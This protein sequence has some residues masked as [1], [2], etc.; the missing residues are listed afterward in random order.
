MCDH[1]DQL[2]RGDFLEQIHDLDRGLGIQRTRRLVGQEDIRIVYQR[3]RDRDA[4]HLSAGHLIWLFVQLIAE[5][6][7]F[8]RLC[9][10]TLAL[11]LSDA[12]D[13]QRELNI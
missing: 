6:D 2:V 3:T 4:L 12:G 10:P 7:L 11:G 8:Q 9:C 5:P 1:N 13:R